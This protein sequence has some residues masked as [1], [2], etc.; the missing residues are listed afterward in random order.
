MMFNWEDTIKAASEK[1]A[2]NYATAPWQNWFW[3][4]QFDQLEN[5][6]LTQAADVQKEALQQL[7]TVMSN[8]LVFCNRRMDAQ[9]S[10]LTSILSLPTGPELTRLTSDFLQ[11]CQSDWREHGN[12]QFSQF[13]AQLSSALDKTQKANSYALEAIEQLKESAEAT[14]EEAAST[15]TAP[16]AASPK[17]RAPVKKA[18]TSPKRPAPKKPAA[19]SSTK[20]KAAAA[21]DV[22]LKNEKSPTAKAPSKTV[23]A[24]AE[25]KNSNGAAV[26]VEPAI[27]P[28]QPAKTKNLEV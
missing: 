24:T 6:T 18:A 19:R 11:T 14:P 9:L 27:L 25:A 22:E 10:L 8:N 16:A 12:N 7:G 20:Q 13:S 1:F 3:A 2:E 21:K 17:R 4:Q 28:E 23:P 15:E 26:M 5:N